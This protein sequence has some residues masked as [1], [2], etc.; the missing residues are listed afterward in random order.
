MINITMVGDRAVIAQLSS[1][2]NGLHAA[3]HRRITILVLQ[4]ERRVKLKLS[5]NVLNVRTGALRR[6]IQSDVRDS[7]QAITGRVFSTGDVKYAAIHEF[8]GRTK[9][10]VIE[11][12]NGKALRFAMGG[13]MVFAK[14]VNHPGSVMP[15]RSFLRSSLREMRD[16]IVQSL[17]DAPAEAMRRS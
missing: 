6:S 17:S 14:R 15:E 7:G 11:A 10:H 12:K 13:A 16:E 2:R 1:F 9:A 4:L 3:L 8:G 5:G